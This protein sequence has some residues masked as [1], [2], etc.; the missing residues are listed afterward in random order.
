[1]LD[2]NA[3][4]IV[5][6]LARNDENDAEQFCR[7]FNSLYTRYVNK[8]YYRWQFFESPHPSFLSLALTAGEDLIGCYGFQLRDSGGVKTAWAIDIMIAPE[9]QGRGLFRQLAD[10]AAHQVLPYKPVALLVMANQRADAAHVGGLL[11]KRVDVIATYMASTSE[12]QIE[13]DSSIEA[14]FVDGLS[15]AYLPPPQATHGGNSDSPFTVHRTR[16]FI[17]WR[18]QNN[19]WYH[20][21]FLQV[22]RR[23]CPFGYLVLKIFQDPNTGDRYGDIVDLAWKEGDSKVITYMLSSALQYFHEKAVLRAAV[24]L[25]GNN[26]LDVVASRLGFRE[27][28][29]KRCFCCKVL[30]NEYRW[31]EDSKRW[32]LTMADSEIY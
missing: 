9:F 7:L 18:F 16:E 17:S 1:M 25:K 29:S 6:R 5:L 20:Y 14:R 8:S 23:N 19:P 31:L 32:F 11:W 12:A 30:D 10:F 13:G 24:W 27:S 21:D 3:M 28:D 15:E 26:V 4:G 22:T 2:T